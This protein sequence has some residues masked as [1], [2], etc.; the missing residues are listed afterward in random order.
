[1]LPYL[2]L[3]LYIISLIT[4]LILMLTAK[5][6]SATNRPSALRW[7][8][9]A[10]FIHLLFLLLFCFRH[11]AA[12][13]GMHASLLL[14][15]SF[16]FYFCSGTALCGWALRTKIPALI[17]IYFALFD[18]SIILFVLMPFNF[19]VFLLSAGFSE[20]TEIKFPVNDHYYIMEQGT[21]MKQSAHPIYRVVR[22]H[23]MFNQ[24]VQYN[25][26]FGGALDSI[27]VLSIINDK[28]ARIRAYIKNATQQ[29]RV[30]SADVDIKLKHEAKDE[31]QQ[32]I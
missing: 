5:S 2:A 28:S 4:S 6:K 8:K 10:T 9:F 17:K 11:F 24:T 29:N 3:A 14:N 16:L 32:Q 23:G 19:S 30:D 13:A 1:M 26:N 31:I 15:L 21:A 25:L 18:A 12:T 22:H 7:F 27:H 20:S